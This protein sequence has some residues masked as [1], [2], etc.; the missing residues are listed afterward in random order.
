MTKTKKLLDLKS[1]LEGIEFLR[2]LVA[3]YNY[4]SEFLN[5]NKTPIELCNEYLRFI[6]DETDLDGNPIED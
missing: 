6:N 3:M 4:R 5:D 1:N 2:G